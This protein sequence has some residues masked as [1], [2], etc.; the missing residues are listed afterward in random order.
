MEGDN[1]VHDLIESISRFTKD[2]KENITLL[3]MLLFSSSRVV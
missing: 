2:K 1:P 3:V